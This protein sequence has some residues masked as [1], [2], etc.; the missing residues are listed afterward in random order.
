MAALSARVAWLGMRRISNS[1]WID[2]DKLAEAQANG[3]LIEASR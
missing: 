2:L 3:L 1:S